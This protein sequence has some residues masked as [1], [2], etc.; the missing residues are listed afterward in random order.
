MGACGAGRRGA[1]RGGSIC[2]GLARSQTIE[3][4]LVSD[5]AIIAAQRLLWSGLRQWVEPGGAAALAALTSG[6][7]KPAPGERV[8]VLVCGA[9]PA[10]GPFD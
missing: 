1:G 4:I 3:S 2:L 10:P 5:E 6:V 8:A 7:Y 9:N